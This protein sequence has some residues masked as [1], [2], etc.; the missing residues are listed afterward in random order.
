MLCLVLAAPRRP[1][2]S[3]LAAAERELWDATPHHKPRR[4]HHRSAPPL[5]LMAAEPGY[6]AKAAASSELTHEIDESEQEERAALDI[7]YRQRD[8]SPIHAPLFNHSTSAERA[9][10]DMTTTLVAAPAPAALDAVQLQLSAVQA[11]LAQ[12]NQSIGARAAPPRPPPP[13]QRPGLC[14]RLLPRLPRGAGGA[15][16]GAPA[17]RRARRHHHHRRARR[18]RRRRSRSTSRRRAGRRRVRRRAR[19][20]RARRRRRREPTAAAAAAAAAAAGRRGAA[21]AAAAAGVRLRGPEGVRRG[22]EGE[23]GRQAQDAPPARSTR[24]ARRRARQAVR[25]LARPRRDLRL[26]DRRGPRDPGLGRGARRLCKGA[27]ATLII[28]PALGYGDRGAGADIPGGATLRFDVEVVDVA[29]APPTAQPAPSVA[30]A[31][32]VASVAA[33]AAL[34]AAAAPKAAEGVGHASTSW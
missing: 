8:A 12:L 15:G 29:G 11:A 23:G 3:A 2:P 30:P 33:A 31:P 18:R 4:P 14:R 6:A 22:V 17:A 19:R 25:Q 7:F 16:R 10:A 21:T 20:R 13:R 34:P 1:N 32:A 24:A 5:N 28:P 27:K 26:R 9:A